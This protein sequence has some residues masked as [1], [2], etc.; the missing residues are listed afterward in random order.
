MASAGFRVCA[1]AASVVIALASVSVD[2]QSK[3]RGGR[4]AGKGGGKVAKPAS[5]WP[6]F[7]ARRGEWVRRKEAAAEAGMNGPDPL[8]Q[9]LVGEIIVTGVF[10][11]DTGMGVFLLATP[12]G[13]TF[14]AAIGATLYNGSLV[15]IVSGSSGFV[16]DT[17]V[18]F[19]ERTGKSG[20]E[21]RIVKRV[22][23]APDPGA[24]EAP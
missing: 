20:G 8:S 9:Y 7:E 17:E 14:F 16:E 13:N 12:T 10:D 21:R 6:S 22:E 5:S 18:V 19:V 2:A 1:F 23:E 15:D 4:P 3:R 24:S 11:T